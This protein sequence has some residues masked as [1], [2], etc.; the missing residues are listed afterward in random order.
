MSYFQNQISSFSTSVI[1]AASRLPQERRPTSTAATTAT[2]PTTTSAPSTSSSAPLT[3]GKRQDADIVY[4]QP[5]NTGTGKDIMTQVVFAIEHMKSKDSPLKFSDIQSYLS[6]HR[7]GHDQ[8]YIHA[9]RR[10]LQSHDKVEYDP[11]GA[12]GE[13]TFRFR[14]PH[15]IRSA[16]QLLQK[17]QSQP[18]AQGMSVR[19]LREGW[20]NIVTAINELE[21][22]GKLLVTR[23]KKDDNPRMVWPNDPSLVHHFDPEFRQIWEKVKIPDQQTVAD[24]LEKA[25]ITPTSKHKPV[26]QRP[27]VEQKK[28]KKPRRSGKTTNTHMAG[29]LRDY[30]HL[31]R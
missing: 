20:P 1:S 18:T 13:G 23:N 5:A 26:K 2:V 9:L 11:K 27:K 4:S 22:D 25:G 7:Q 10:I 28:V 3:N 24:E 19:E 6:L 15:N 14:P 12:Q 16:D 30:S 17:L 21:R 8:A 31:K 29:I